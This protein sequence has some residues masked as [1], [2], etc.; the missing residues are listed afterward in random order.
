M[1][2][3]YQHVFDELRLEAARRLRNLIYGEPAKATERGVEEG[4][5][6]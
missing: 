4:Q 3:R 1:L 5:G 2:R 6:A